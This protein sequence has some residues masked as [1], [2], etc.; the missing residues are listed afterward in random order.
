M[1]QATVQTD[2][3]GRVP[4]RLYKKM[5]RL[6]VSPSDWDDIADAYELIAQTPINFSQ[7]EKF[8]DAHT[9]GGMYQPP[10][11]LDPT[12]IVTL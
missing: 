8:I 5:S 10:W 4:Y 12:N 2:S 6:N 9:T 11:P 1:A 7:A 3:Y